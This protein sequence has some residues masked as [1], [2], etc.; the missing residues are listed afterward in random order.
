MKTLL[1]IYIIIPLVF[2]QQIVEEDQ[3]CKVRIVDCENKQLQPKTQMISGK[4]GPR[5]LKGEPG[6]KGAIGHPGQNCN[7][8][9]VKELEHKLERFSQKVNHRVK[10][11]E[12]VVEELLQ[13]KNSVL[14]SCQPDEIENASFTP[15]SSVLNATIVQYQCNEGFSTT[16]LDQRTCVNNELQPSFDKVPFKCFKDCIINEPVKWVTRSQIYKENS[17]KHGEAVRFTC[18]HQTDTYYDITCENGIFNTDDVICYPQSCQE[19]KLDDE[20]SQSKVYGIKPENTEIDVYCDLRNENEGWIVIQK[21]NERLL[22]FNQNWENSKNGFGDLN[23]EFWLGLENI[24]QLTKNKD[25]ILRVDLIDTDD[26]ELYVQYE[27]FYIGD[28][29]LNYVFLASGH[30]GQIGDIFNEGKY[31]AM[32]QSFTTFDRDNDKLDENCAVKYPSAW[33]HKDCFRTNLNGD[34]SLHHFRVYDGRYT[35]IKSSVMKIRRAN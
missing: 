4:K 8:T 27:N 16:D 25:M 5:G 11:L 18:R 15:S 21:R 2:S 30:S 7:C 33:W 26:N 23:G 17:I 6:Q 9:Y 34:V 28:E 1:L 12:L 24:H 3:Q 14:A 10:K 20:S 31:T 32:G 22:N 29:T 13:Y 19:I 35:D